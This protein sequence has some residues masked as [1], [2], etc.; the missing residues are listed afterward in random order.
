M[1]FTLSGFWQAFRGALVVSLVSIALS[2][3]FREEAKRK[4]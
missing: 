4:S 2:M 3:V 1:S